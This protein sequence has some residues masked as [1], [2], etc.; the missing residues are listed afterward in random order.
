MAQDTKVVQV[1]QVT[2]ICDSCNVGELTGF[3]PTVKGKYEYICP[4]C[5]AVN[6][7][8]SLYPQIIYTPI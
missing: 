5:Q 6:L 2:Y 1:S 3:A 4:N 8:N 7:L